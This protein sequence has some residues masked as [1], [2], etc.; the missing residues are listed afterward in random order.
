MNHSSREVAKGLRELADK[1][2]SIPEFKFCSG[3]DDIVADKYF[4]TGDDS[5]RKKFIDAI[6]SLGAF[7]KEFTEDIFRAWCDFSGGVRLKFYAARSSVCTKRTV[8]VTKEVEVDEWDCDS[9]LEQALAA[10]GIVGK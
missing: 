9:I 3:I 5:S 6:K 1:L 4:F 2:D 7:R 8:K 10:E